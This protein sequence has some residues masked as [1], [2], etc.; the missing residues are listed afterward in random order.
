[1]LWE[2]IAANLRWRGESKEGFYE[3]VV[4]KNKTEGWVGY[5]YIYITIYK[6]DF[7]EELIFT[8]QFIQLI[9]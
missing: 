7:C 4:F 9:K 6:I 5:I 1:M 3:K 2:N 8:Y